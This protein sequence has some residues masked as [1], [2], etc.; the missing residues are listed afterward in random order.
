MIHLRA[1]DDLVEQ[2]AERLSVCE[3]VRVERLSDKADYPVLMPRDDWKPIDQETLGK[4]I[5]GGARRVR[6]NCIGLMSIPEYAHAPI[7]SFLEWYF[8]GGPKDV[9]QCSR[10][11]HRLDV[12]RQIYDAP[13]C[14]RTSTRPIFF[15]VA[16]NTPD[17]SCATIDRE[18]D[19][20]VGLHI[21]NFDNLPSSQ[22]MRGRNRISANVGT[23]SRYFIFMPHEAAEMASLI[24]ASSGQEDAERLE[25][26]QRELVWRFFELFPRTPIYRVEVRPG[27]AYMAPTENIMHEGSTLGTTADDWSIVWFGEFDWDRLRFRQ[28]PDD[29][30]ASLRLRRQ[31]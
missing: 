30:D 11:E 17:A 4:F 12:L 27:E 13:E 6:G 23:E 28:E 18:I 21:D 29:G 24:L 15:G 22:R 25:W 9:E 31:A 2:L 16:R 19:S 14:P 5:R 1:S 8:E 10:E 3:G 7:L 20:L 26:D